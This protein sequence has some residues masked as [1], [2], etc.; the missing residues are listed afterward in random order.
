MKAAFM[1]LAHKSFE[2]IEYLIHALHHSAIDVYIHV[3][4]KNEELYS[5]LLNKYKNSGRVYILKNRVAVNRGGLSVVEASL[6]LMK[7]AAQK[8]YQYV[9]LISGQ[10]FPIKSIE[11]IL[12]FLEENEGNQYIE[13]GEI[14]PNFWRLKCFNFFS[15]NKHNRKTIIRVLDNICRRPQK[16]LIRRKNFKG[17]NLYKGST[18]FTITYDCLKYML[19]HIDQNPIYLSDYRFSYCPDESFFHNL[20]LNSE[21]KKNVINNDLMEIDWIH[22]YQ[23]SPRVYSV[24]DYGM[25]ISS[26]KL[27][28]RKFDIEHDKEIVLKL[29]NDAKKPICA[30]E[31]NHK[32]RNVL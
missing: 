21:Y 18:W 13:G 11:Y 30:D 17:F 1:V 4:K 6:A 26:D 22:H 24:D 10:C 28:A 16:I 12:N 19:N 25:L 9:S 2:Q 15:E 3:D 29:M 32:W 8:K 23:G 7:E 14:G 31:E 5:Q 27:F 20:I